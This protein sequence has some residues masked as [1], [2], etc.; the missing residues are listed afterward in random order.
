MPIVVVTHG[1]QT[2]HTVSMHQQAAQAALVVLPVSSYALL[3]WLQTNGS[4]SKHSRDLC[5]KSK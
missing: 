3:I 4:K 1:L 2:L 5:S